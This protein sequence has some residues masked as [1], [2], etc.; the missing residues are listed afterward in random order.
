[1]T[2]RYASGRFWALCGVLASVLLLV[3]L[4]LG[5]VQ[6][7]RSDHWSE[8]AANRSSRIVAL[9]APRGRILDRNGAVLAVTEVRTNIGFAPGAPNASR[10]DPTVLARI[11]GVSTQSLRDRLARAKGFVTLARRVVLAPSDRDILLRLPGVT[12][13]DRLR[14]RHPHGDLALRL[15]GTVSSAGEGTNGLEK[16]LDGLLAGQR[17]EELQRF[18][19]WE[20]L[21]ARVPLHPPRSGSDVRLTLD[22]KVQ[23]ILEAELDSAR[24]RT[25]ARHVQGIVL[26]PRNGEVLALAQVPYALDSSEVSE[27]TDTYR[28]MAAT[29]LFEP[30]SSFKLLTT[31]SLLSR[32]VCDSSTIFD[33][34]ARETLGRRSRKV[35]ED[36]QKIHDTHGVGIV[37]L[38]RAFT[39]SSNIVYATAAESLLKSEF[40]EDLRRFGIGRALGTGLPSEENGL[41]LEPDD[42]TTAHHRSIA[43]G[44]GVSVTLLQMSAAYA[45]LI[46]DGYLRTPQ[47]V[48]SWVTPEGEKCLP[49]D[50]RRGSERVIP[51]RIIPILRDFCRSV[52]EE[53]G[54]TGRRAHVDGLDIGGKTGTAQV[55]SRTGGYLH[56]V[57]TPNFLGFVPASDPRLLVGIVMHRVPDRYAS[58]GRDAAPVFAELIRKIAASTRYLDAAAVVEGPPTSLETVPNLIGRSAADVKRLAAESGWSLGNVPAADDARAVGQI[59]RAGSRVQTGTRVRVTWTGAQS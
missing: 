14:R 27:E 40:Y 4:R 2:S 10:L 7:V 6:L 38:R 50:A 47:L 58:G 22:A 12:L 24:V 42:W 41:L 44:Q 31:A 54:G 36:G 37:S 52:V 20:R 11:L 49:P 25:G 8:R 39:V 3:V 53:V 43:Y 48:S 17:G 57:F 28:V 13:E 32:S 15:L 16:A 5:W 56:E 55:P 18:D 34:L 26:D 19:R 9:P 33:G 45:A 59:P 35:F 51:P 21:R 46:G 29:D 1:M 30:G 23:G